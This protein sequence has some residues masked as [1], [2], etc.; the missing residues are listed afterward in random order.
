M[1][2]NSVFPH[3]ASQLTNGARRR[4]DSSYFAF[5]HGHHLP[6]EADLVILDFDTEDQTD[7]QARDHFEV[8]VRSILNRRDSPAV[9][10]LGHFSPQFQVAFGF[11]GPEIQHSTV[12]QYYD[13]PHISIKGVMYQE[14]LA[15]PNDYAANYHVDPVLANAKGHGIIADVL[16]SYF[17]SQICKGWEVAWGYAFDVPMLS[18]EPVSDVK[19]LFGGIRAGGDG[20]MNGAK[21]EPRKGTK[22]NVQNAVD[23]AAFRIPNGRLASRPWELENFREA[24]P[25]CVA[26]DDLINPL[27]PSLFYGSGWH[28]HHPDGGDDILHYWYSVL[29]ASKIRIPIKV[30][31]GD[32]A[33]FYLEE[34]KSIK[35]SSSVQWFVVSCHL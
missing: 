26:A 3:P 15:G 31:A 22:G 7:S 24:E 12:A 10:V 5:C 21:H 11:H 20:M 25:Y 23:Y 19:G 14:Y 29:P 30:G 35:D 1:W 32:I 34:G 27:P 16:I 9:L 33:I 6:D 2:W 17:Q 28:V 4:T 13:V 8:L 18:S